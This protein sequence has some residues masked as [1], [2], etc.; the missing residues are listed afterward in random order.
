ML[1]ATI[2]IIVFV[3]Q[4]FDDILDTK[5]IKAVLDLLSINSLYELNVVFEIAE[6]EILSCRNSPEEFFKELYHKLHTFCLVHR[7]FKET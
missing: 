4:E 1:K 7:L 5:N 3:K 2:D 6:L